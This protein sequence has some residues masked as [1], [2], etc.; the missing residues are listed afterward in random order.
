MENQ[1]I[2]KLSKEQKMINSTT[3]ININTNQIKLLFMIK[4]LTVKHI[5]GIKL[6]GKRHMKDVS[7][8]I[9]KIQLSFKQIL[10]IER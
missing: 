9:Q 4:Q 1:L 7:I 8:I 2:D 6:M 10:I 5:G 3:S